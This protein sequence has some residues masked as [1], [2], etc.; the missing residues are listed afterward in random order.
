LI[1]SILIALQTAV[2]TQKKAILFCNQAL[3]FC[4]QVPFLAIFG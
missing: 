1:F 3:Y 4:N 2:T